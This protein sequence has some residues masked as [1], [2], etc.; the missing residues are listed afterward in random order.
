M[1]TMRWF[2]ARGGERPDGGSCAD[3]AEV[4]RTD[5]ECCAGVVQTNPAQGGGV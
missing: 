3:V 2:Y 1:R 4:N 5:A